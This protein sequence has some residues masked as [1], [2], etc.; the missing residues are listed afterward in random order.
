[1]WENN[2]I[3]ESLYHMETLYGEKV[4]DE[5][6]EWKR[7]NHLLRMTKDGPSFALDEVNEFL[8]ARNKGIV[9]LPDFETI[10]K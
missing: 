7:R 4:S 3:T 1:M 2:N 8:N 10:C 9:T 5:E 6:L